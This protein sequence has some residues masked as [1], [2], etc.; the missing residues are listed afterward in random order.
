MSAL[1]PGALP[2]NGEIA[3]AAHV[4]NEIRWRRFRVDSP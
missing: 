4:L 1:H 3:L 2:T